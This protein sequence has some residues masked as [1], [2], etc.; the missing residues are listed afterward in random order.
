MTGRVWVLVGVLAGMSLSQPL[1]RDVELTIQSFPPCEV[2]LETPTGR[3]R[4][5]P[6]GR[7]TRVTPPVLRDGDGVPVQY[8]PATLV[9]TAADHAELRVPVNAADWTRGKLPTQG[10]YR[11]PAAS[12]AVAARDYVVVYPFLSLALAS[13]ALGALAAAVRWR[14]QARSRQQQV[15]QLSS[16]LHTTGDPLIGKQLGNYRVVARLGQGGMGSVYR[17]R[18]DGGDYAAKVLYF[19]SLDAQ[20]LERFRREFKVLSRLR[21]PALPR[22]YDYAEAEGMAFGVME[23]VEG[24][25]LQHYIRPGGLPWESVWPWVQ[26]ILLG[27]ECAHEQ[28][29]VH[30]D[31]KPGNLMV[32]SGRI[33][34]L[35]FGLARQSE[36]TAVTL[37]GQGFG[38]PTYMAPEQVSASGNEVDPRTDIYSLG[39]ILFELLTG[40]PPF[41]GSEVQEVIAQHMTCQPPR[42][43]T[44]VS[45]VP[46]AVE[47]A[48]EVMLAKKPANRYANLARVR[49]VLTGAA[50][51]GALPEAQEG[52][53][54]GEATTEVRRP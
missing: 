54:E 13:A 9:L 45:G 14:T 25:T 36:L 18:A 26:D 16:Q 11:L 5:A 27:L 34:I 32:T 24:K 6:S 2:Y 50:A 21:H 20:E 15:Q 31:L 37:T 8:A 23:L 39:I 35:D 7:S 1:P 47:E 52:Q 19:S 40:E 17:V 12:L 46:P 43:S 29:I 41:R 48:I 38:T 49:E 28:G 4:L 33:K 30:R 51:R 22:A 53:G 10:V 3:S 42:V 44:L